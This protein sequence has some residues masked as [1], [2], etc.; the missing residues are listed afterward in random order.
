MK[1]R[2]FKEL[3]QRLTKEIENSSWKETEK[4]K[5][6]KEKWGRE[7]YKKKCK[8]FKVKELDF[9]MKQ[10]SFKSNKQF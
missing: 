10:K 9:Y 4:K 1:K 2:M 5:K 7:A 6:E 8:Y 3:I